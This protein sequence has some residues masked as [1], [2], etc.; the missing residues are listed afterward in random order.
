MEMLDYENL[1]ETCRL[2]LK[3]DGIKL[4][5]FGEV[6]LQRDVAY[7]INVCF[8][9]AIYETDPL[10]K[11]IC[12]RCLYKLDQN[13]EFRSDVFSAFQQL[14][15]A[16][17]LRRSDPVIDR[18]LSIVEDK[19]IVI[20]RSEICHSG[21]QHE[22]ELTD[23][24]VNNN[25]IQPSGECI[26]FSGHNTGDEDEQMEITKHIPFDVVPPV[27]VHDV[28]LDLQ[29]INNS[30]E[31]NY[32][33]GQDGNEKTWISDDLQHQA[34]CDN[35]I[36][37][38]KQEKGYNTVVRPQNESETLSS[39]QPG[40]LTKKK[41]KKQGLKKKQ[42]AP[43]AENEDL[44]WCNIC[45][46]YLK[47]KKIFRQHNARVHNAV[48]SPIYECKCKRKYPSLFEMLTHQQTH[49]KVNIKITEDML[50]KCNLCNKKFADNSILKLHST[51]HGD[52]FK[53]NCL[54]KSYANDLDFVKKFK[55]GHKEKRLINV[56]APPS[57][58]FV[59]DHCWQI[60]DTASSLSLHLNS[61]HCFISCNCISGK[62]NISDNSS[63]HHIKEIRQ[64][65]VENVSLDNIQTTSKVTDNMDHP[66]Q[67]TIS[68]TSLKSSTGHNQSLLA[69]LVNQ[70]A[71]SAKEC[72]SKKVLKKHK[73]KDIAHDTISLNCGFCDITFEKRSSLI[74][75][76]HRHLGGESYHC[77]YCT[78]IFSNKEIFLSHKCLNDKVYPFC[79]I[80]FSGYAVEFAPQPHENGK[81]FLSSLDHNNHPQKSQVNVSGRNWAGNLEQSEEKE[82]EYTP[83][84]SKNCNEN[85]NRKNTKKSNGEYSRACPSSRN[86]NCVKCPFCYHLVNP[87]S[88][89]QHIYKNHPDSNNI[90]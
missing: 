63:V 62:K 24:T 40:I 7:K 26:T 72:S 54:F 10:P 46:K 89:Y 69:S 17:S 2:C 36:E 1:K 84:K 65:T 77:K 25:P 41:E 15:K 90:T 31:V 5:I 13:Y 58:L 43:I 19:K 6:G 56:T 32:L 83:K 12:H 76:L 59:C 21:D 68:V 73:K 9:L 75:H 60:F 61:K 47:T 51:T 42:A 67:K 35:V 37:V 52:K 86:E 30:S 11:L 81:E 14:K 55:I 87:E 18:Y 29:T 8:A 71:L 20:G 64:G 34:H 23:E 33:F 53:R 38:D 85:N 82:K 44:Q 45:Q 74:S 4:Q 50:L 48:R 22:S 88:M 49:L 66:S 80:Q 78:K 28:A 39:P 16:L 57:E 27:D 70:R 79:D 3:P